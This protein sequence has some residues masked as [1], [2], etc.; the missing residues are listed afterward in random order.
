M[1]SDSLTRG[2][3]SNEI[4][5]IGISTS[6]NGPCKEPEDKNCDRVM[7]NIDK[8]RDPVA[9]LSVFRGLRFE[10]SGNISSLNIK[11][12]NEFG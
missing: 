3:S 4:V 12:S 1:N 8:D 6:S 2:W 5:T 9:P 11:E 7:E 10:V